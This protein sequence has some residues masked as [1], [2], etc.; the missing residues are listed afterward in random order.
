MIKLLLI[1][2]KYFLKVMFNKFDEIYLF[3]LFFLLI[4]LSLIC[5]RSNS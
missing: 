2:Y 1:Q 3:Y 5:E 4:N